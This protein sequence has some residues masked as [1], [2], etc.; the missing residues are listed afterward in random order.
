MKKGIA[1][2][3]LSLLL[4]A[5]L[6]SCGNEKD[7][8]SLAFPKTSWGMT[9]EE[10]LEAYGAAKEDAS[11][12]NEG[13]YGTAF[14]LEGQ[15]IF[16]EEASRVFFNFMAVGSEP[17]RLCVVSVEYPDDADMGKVWKEMR[18]SY[19]DSV[20]EITRY[21]PM[22]VIPG[23]LLET[24][25]TEA[26][27]VK[28]WGSNF[29]KQEVSQEQWDGYRTLW[30]GPVSLD[31]EEESWESFYENAR[32]SEAYWSNGG[33]I[34]SSENAL[35]FE[36]YNLLVYNQ[37]KSGYTW[38]EMNEPEGDTPPENDRPEGDTQPENNGTE[39]A[40]EP[41]ATD[42]LEE[43]DEKDSMIAAL[44][45]MQD[46]EWADLYADYNGESLQLQIS[47]ENSQASPAL[48]SDTVFFR[49]QEGET[50]SDI[51]N[52]M[53]TAMLMPL[54]E[55]EEGRTF[56]ITEFRVEEQELTAIGDN[57]WL[58]PF[59]KVYY[60][61]E[62]IDVVSMETYRETEPE[63]EKDG[64]MPLQREGSESVFSFVLSERD[65]VYRLQRV[66]DVLE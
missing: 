25:T 16:G 11:M 7:N 34:L 35:Y 32:L 50:L 39:E 64:L 49:P 66:Q 12:W 2:T 48:R 33:G 13:E 58:L 41:K 29:V 46:S 51:V 9:V 19:G 26:E 30:Q 60:S 27:N 62:G 18:K 59:L 8:G 63:L 52:Q 20:S 21:Q 47:E 6:T 38:P 4:S 24:H 40:D 45:E 1:V 37:M 42:K 61:Y 65:G 28:L 22:T 14:A 57:L 44:K 3:I 55:P 53:I 31:V 23:S 43:A 56:T 17:Q 15:E 36:A 5:V 10:V 54:K